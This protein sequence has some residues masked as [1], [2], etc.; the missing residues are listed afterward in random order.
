ML[1]VKRWDYRIDAGKFSIEILNRSCTS[2]WCTNFYWIFCNDDVLL[3]NVRRL[4]TYNYGYWVGLLFEN[5]V[6]IEGIEKK[7]SIIKC[8]IN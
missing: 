5:M 2:F 4:G 8:L 7:L 3:L 6:L 1:L